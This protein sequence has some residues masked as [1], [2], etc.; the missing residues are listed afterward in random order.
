MKTCSEYCGSVHARYLL[1]MAHALR[2]RFHQREEK[3]EQCY[4]ISYTILQRMKP[5]IFVCILI[6]FFALNTSCNG[7]GRECNGKGLKN[8]NIDRVE[9]SIMLKCSED[10]LTLKEEIEK[11]LIGEWKLIGFASGSTKLNT[12]PCIY[13]QFSEKEVIVE[14]RNIEIDTIARY[15]W[16]IEE[17]N[18]SNL[19]DSY[20]SLKV[21]PGYIN[22]LRQ[23]NVFC[24]RYMYEN[25]TRFHGNMYLYEKVK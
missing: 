6:T 11:N 17:I 18:S 24:K 25:A 7:D 19:N 4:S 8:N 20:L 12:Q 23:V 15:P 1:R 22:G 16:E 5:L 10:K 13:L 2:V 21:P 9:R 14:S 3:R